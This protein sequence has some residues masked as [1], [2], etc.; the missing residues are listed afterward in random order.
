MVLF[1]HNI[2]TVGPIKENNNFM[3]LFWQGGPY[4]D[5][6]TIGFLNGFGTNRQKPEGPNLAD[7]GVSGSMGQYKI[8]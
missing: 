1:T 3:E 5:K 6:K 7:Q 4:D 8:I 2:W